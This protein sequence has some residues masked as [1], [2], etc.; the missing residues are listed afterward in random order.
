MLSMYKNQKTRILFLKA[1]FKR[2]LLF[3]AHGPVC[4]FDNVS[5]VLSHRWLTS[6]HRFAGLGI[7]NTIAVFQSYV[8]TH[9]LTEY[10]ESSIGWIFSLYTFLAFFCGVY[11]GPIFDKFGP[12]WLILAG[13]GLVTLGLMLLSVCESQSKLDVRAV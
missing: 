4:T 13:V 9:Q 12:R 3:S 5:P 1:E 8:S 11:I 7:T 6:Y 10:S 2:G